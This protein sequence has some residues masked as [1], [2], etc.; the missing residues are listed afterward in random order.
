M[1]GEKWGYNTNDSDEESKKTE[2]EMR[3]I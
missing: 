2:H 3:L 1:V